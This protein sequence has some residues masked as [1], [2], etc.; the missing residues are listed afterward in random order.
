ML[1]S[2]LV[3]IK[4][5]FPTYS[6]VG[7]RNFLLLSVCILNCQT[8]CLNR[9]KSEVSIQRGKL[10]TKLDS[11]YKF[12][13]RFFNQYGFSRLWLTILRFCVRFLRLKS[14]A[15]VLDSTS[16]Q[17]GKKQYHFLVLSVVYQGVAIP[18]YWEDL[19]KKGI[20]NQQERKRL[21]RKALK[22][23]DLRQMTLSR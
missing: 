19:N 4:A 10:E 6:E 20:S 11:H 2:L 1:D 17:H 13:C 23:F 21:L 14:Q 5:N 12:L 8:V 3:K 15:L 16:W 18:I 22:Q 9:L 7:V